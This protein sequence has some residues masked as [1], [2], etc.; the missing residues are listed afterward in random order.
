MPAIESMNRSEI[1]VEQHV[2]MSQHTIQ[3]L[4]SEIALAERR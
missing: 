4:L 3:V 1:L 2:N